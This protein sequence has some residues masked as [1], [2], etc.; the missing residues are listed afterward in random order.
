LRLFLFQEVIGLIASI[1]F[2]TNLMAWEIAH[3]VYKPDTDINQDAVHAYMNKSEKELR[4]LITTEGGKGTNVTMKQVAYNMSRMYQKTRDATYADKAVIL[5]ERFAEVVPEWPMLSR[6]GIPIPLDKVDWGAWDNGGLWGNWHHTDL[7]NSLELILAY[8]YIVASGA[9][10]RRGPNTRRIIEENLLK[11]IVEF[12]LKCSYL[13]RVYD[14][15]DNGQAPFEYSNMGGKKINGIIPFGRILDPK[16]IHLVVNFLRHYPSVAYFRDG[17]WS[18]SSLSYHKQITNWLVWKLI[19]QLNG[20]SDPAGFV[21]PVDGTRFDNLEI[22]KGMKARFNRIR[23]A[24]QNLTLPNGKLLALH[25]TH[26][27]QTSPFSRDFSDS[28]CYFGMRHAVLGRFSGDNQVQVHLHFGG[29]D[30]HEHYDCLSLVVWALGGELISEGEYCKY[31]TRNW[32]LATA[33]HNGV[34][35][36]QV[37]QRGRFNARLKQTKDDYVDKLSYNPNVYGHGDTRNFGNLRIWDPTH[38]KMQIVEADG[39]NAYGRNK[40]SHYRRTIAMIEIEDNSFYLI[41]VFR[42]KG[43]NIH[44]WM[45]HGNLGEDYAFWSDLNWKSASGSRF[46]YLD[47]K[48]QARTNSNWFSEF[49]YESGARIRTIMLGHPDTEVSIGRA[50]AM[51]RYGDA[52][53]MDVRRSGGDNIFVAVH[54]P[55]KTAP[56]VENVTMLECSGKSDSVVTL[57]VEL[58]GGRI[59]HFSATL[60]VPPYPERTIKLTDFT[61]Q[62]RIVHIAE[63]SGDLLWVYLLE[64]ASIR[65]KNSKIDISAKSGDFSYRGQITDVKRIEKGDSWNGFITNVDLPKDG[66]LSNKTLL[67]T[68]GDGRTEGYTISHI[69]EQ[70]KKKKSLIHVNEEQGKKKKSLIH[71]NEEQGK[72]KKS[73][74][75]V[76]EEPGLELRDNGD[77]AK[78][79]YFPWHGVRGKISFLISGSVYRNASGDT[80]TTA[81]WGVTAKPFPP[82]DFIIKN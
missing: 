80:Q 16:Y 49:Q 42:V 38:P 27:N 50:P 31:G 4:S 59:D 8:D 37:N 2:A 51:R 28:Y 71:V 81:K 78:L 44:D 72:K 58:K 43:G 25:D 41:D 5:L 29:T 24:M 21:D 26:S 7:D 55:Y 35:I 14:L 79:V 57:K 46:G 33:G 54:E 76:N 69:E 56:K 82:A 47:I 17:L 64:G 19:P 60:D 62:G 36:D 52:T 48:N 74:I 1:I 6:S 32:N 61:F 68:L 66:R 12:N 73:L 39:K 15:H 63:K 40:V 30:G 22:E 65:K 3:P 77:L 9:M 23:G 13:L 75:H 20:Y 11:Y 67:L 34:V 70:G 45:L 18:E 10:D 53:F